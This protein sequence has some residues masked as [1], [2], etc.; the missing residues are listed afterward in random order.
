[1]EGDFDPWIIF[2]SMEARAP[3]Y[4]NRIGHFAPGGKNRPADTVAQVRHSARFPQARFPHDDSS[5]SPNLR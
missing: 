5:Q 4:D 3:V 1:M 2:F